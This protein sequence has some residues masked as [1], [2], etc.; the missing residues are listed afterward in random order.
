MYWQENVLQRCLREK[1]SAFK[2]KKIECQRS[3]KQNAKKKD[4]IV[5]ECERIKQQQNRQQKQRLEEMSVLDVANKNIK[6]WRRV[7]YMT[8]SLIEYLA[9]K[10]LKNVSHSF[11]Q[12]LLLDQYLYVHAATKHGL[13]KVSP[14]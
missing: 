14:C 1:D 5:L 6:V 7:I 13:E 9:R 10:V 11:I 8:I 2:E 4:P 3:S 12:I